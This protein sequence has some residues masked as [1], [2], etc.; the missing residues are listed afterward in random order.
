MAFV[1]QFLAVN[2]VGWE[3]FVFVVAVIV[4]VSVLV[5][6][7]VMMGRGK[8]SVSGMETVKGTVMKAVMCCCPLVHQL[9]R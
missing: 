4:R 6:R 7:M 9:R 8:E 5:L 3:N 1:V 2:D